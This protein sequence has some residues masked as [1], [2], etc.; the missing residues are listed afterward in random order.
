M[1]R[2]VIA[3]GSGL[4][5]RELAREFRQDNHEVII[6]SRNP[7]NA[8]QIPEGV[9]IIAWDGK[10]QQGWGNWVEGA[11]A[12]INLSGA[13]IAGEGFLPARWTEERKSI[14][15]VS[16]IDAGN[17]ITEAIS[18]ASEKPKVLVQSSAIGYYGP[19][20]NEPVDET[21]AAGGDFM[22]HLCEEWEQST[23]PVQTIGVRCVVIRSGI[24]LSNKGGALT[25][26]LLP[27]KLF[28]GG[29]FGNG[30]QVMSWIHISDE[31]NAIRFLIDNPSASGVYNLTAPNPVTNN[32]MGKAIGRVM[33][34]PH[35]LPV[36]GFVMRLSFGEVS[37]VVLGGQRVLPSRLLTSG[38]QFTFPTIDLALGD[39]L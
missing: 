25:R 30:R 6:L 33:H 29:R 3:G 10:T 28:A 27:Y 16:R 37:A 36:P 5:G 14:I 24:V 23:A 1:M 32:E 9:K 2:I 22:A 15:R 31:V 13:N 38:Y 4:I 12:V 34:R 39:I 8:A 19:L 11:D 21:A 18:S 20:K 7:G 26:I 35:Y 17:A